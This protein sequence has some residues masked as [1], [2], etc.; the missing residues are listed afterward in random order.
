[1]IRQGFFSTLSILL[2]IGMLLACSTAPK[3]S[4]LKVDTDI[5]LSGRWNDTD[6]RLVA[7]EMIKDCLYRPWL[8]RFK[9]GHNGQMPSVIVGH[10]RNRSHEHIN[11][12]TFIKNLER[13]LINSGQV[14]FVASSEE[15]GQ[16]RDE[17]MD[18]AEHASD[19]T[20]KGPGQEIGADFMLIGGFNSILDQIR[21]KSVMYYQVNL[22]LISL[23]NNVKAW[24]GEK[25]IKKLVE[26][27]RV[28]W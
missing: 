23:E 2:T 26:R 16:I 11:V 24:I 22:E 28:T 1:M 20:M 3:V 8:S 10:V 12:Q 9:S 15:R 14:Q 21:G 17:R 4:R 19:E 13:A 27:P 18:M 7:E 6:S 25:Q 5:E